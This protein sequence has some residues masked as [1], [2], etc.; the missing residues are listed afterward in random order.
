[1]VPGLAVDRLEQA[2]LLTLPRV[3]RQPAGGRTASRKVLIGDFNGDGKVN[4]SDL[5]LVKNA[6]SAAYNVFADFNGDGVVD[7]NDYNI[8]RANL[9]KHL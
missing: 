9:N 7:L 6:L 2:Q 3:G 5:Q 8:C 1:M 4:A